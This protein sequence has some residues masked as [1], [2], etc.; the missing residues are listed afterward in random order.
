LLV[1]CNILQREIAW[2]ANKN[3]WEL[4]LRFRAAG[5]CTETVDLEPPFGTDLECASARPL[6]VFYGDCHHRMT[7]WIASASAVRIEGRNC[8]EILL[9]KERYNA[10]LAAGAYF[11]LESAARRWE[12]TLDRV[13]GP[14]R[15]V[16]RQIFRL[17][18]SYFLGVTTPCT[19]DYSSLAEVIASSIGLPLR[20]TNVPLCYLE[21]A[22]Q[23]AI[24]R[25]ARRSPCPT[26]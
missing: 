11:L 21:A 5:L 7:S 6:V 18:R 1:G 12:S 19:E 25:A 26:R 20:W 13:F 24:D 17:D 16:A 14:H 10:E 23:A 15:S 8:A 4:E 22:L 3:R 9:G 2:L